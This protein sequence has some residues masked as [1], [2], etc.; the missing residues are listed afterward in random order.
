MPSIESFERCLRLWVSEEDIVAL[1]GPFSRE[2]NREMLRHFGADALVTKESGR[3]GGLEEKIQ[4]A[5]DLGIKVILVERPPVEY[6]E[7]VSEYPKVLEWLRERK[8]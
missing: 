7:M 3:V 6:G 4:A 5:L 2:L 1:Q 8:I